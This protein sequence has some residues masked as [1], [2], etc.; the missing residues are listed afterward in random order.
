MFLC[1]P[2]LKN[3]GKAG[4]EK[5]L[6]KLIKKGKMDE[7]NKNTILSRITE[8]TD[9]NDLADCDLIIEAASE[10][11][12]LKKKAFSQY[13]KICKPETILATNTSSLSITE[14]ASSTNRPDKVIGMHFFNPAA[15]NFL[16]SNSEIALA[17]I[18]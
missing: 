10:D 17:D 15:I 6:A 1:L 18:T 9:V 5:T 7:E 3:K 14:I 11:M 8:T 16:P 13:D 2:E 4:V 12:Q